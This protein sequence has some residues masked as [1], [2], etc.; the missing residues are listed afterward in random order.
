[1]TTFST[2]LP[3]CT[4]LLPQSCNRGQV[5]T[6]AH[7]LAAAIQHRQHRSSSTFEV[8]VQQP[9]PNLAMKG[10]AG[11]LA[12]PPLSLQEHTDLHAYECVHSPHLWLGPG[13]ANCRCAWSQRLCGI[14]WI[15][16]WMDAGVCVAFLSVWPS[17]TY[18]AHKFSLIHYYTDRKEQIRMMTI[19]QPPNA[20]NKT[21]FMTSVTLL[22]IS[23]LGC[24]P[25]NFF[26]VFQYLKPTTLFTSS[27][28]SWSCPRQP[29]LPTTSIQKPWHQSSLSTHLL[30]SGFC[31]CD[32]TSCKL[33]QC[34]D[35]STN[36]LVTSNG[37]VAYCNIAQGIPAWIDLPGK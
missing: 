27:A 4:V 7:P 21:Q 8:T 9:T 3:N 22:H 2:S 36:T 24:H 31:C 19:H 37:L 30:C 23:V 16:G 33:T 5:S 20:P 10:S 13:L 1:M 17:E 29:V 11:I 25:H 12:P 14:T 32:H 35:L 18:Y 28:K 6:S 26:P 15:D 34:R